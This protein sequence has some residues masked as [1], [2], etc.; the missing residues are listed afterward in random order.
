MENIKIV[1][2]I[3]R[4]RKNVR[5]KHKM[6]TI[7]FYLDKIDKKGLAPIHLRINCKGTQTKLSTGSKVDPKRFDKETQRV[8]GNS[9]KAK[10]TNHYLT[11]LEE[12][13]DELK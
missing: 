3:V 10:E 12:R 7:N 4:V 6:A 9:K 11:F 1:R 8:I 5:K 13:A 2:N